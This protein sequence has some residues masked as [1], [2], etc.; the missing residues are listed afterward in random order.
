MSRHQK[1]I[2]KILGGT[3]DTN[4]EFDELCRLLERLGFER[5]T[6]GSHSVFRR[7]GI[8]E[9]INLQTT[10]HLAKPYQVKQVR[11]MILKNQLGAEDV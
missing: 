7:D 3:S 10:G 1:L 8:I 4:I 9:K 5:R 11:S 6:K 2:Q